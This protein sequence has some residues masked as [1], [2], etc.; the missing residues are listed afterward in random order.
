[1]DWTPIWRSLKFSL[2]LIVACLG[3]ILAGQ[4]QRNGRR[5]AVRLISSLSMIMGIPVLLGAVIVESTCVKRS[6]AIISPD[7]KHIAFSETLGQGALGDDYA[8]VRVRRSWSLYSENVYNGLGAWDF[9]HKRQRNPEVQW[10]DNSTLLIRYFD[11]RKGNEEE[12]GQRFVRI[13]PA[14]SESNVST[15][16]TANEP[17]IRSRFYQPHKSQS[18][19]SPFFVP[20]R[21]R[22]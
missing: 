3:F 5:M 14:V 6:P 8:I 1:M 15:S 20:K 9:E 12:S 19:I 13:D 4:M 11:D 7:G 17:P 22:L 10:L 21:I 18:P 2:P 16:Q